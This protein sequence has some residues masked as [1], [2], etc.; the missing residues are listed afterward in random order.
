V[1]SFESYD[2]AKKAFDTLIERQLPASQLAILGADLKSAT[3]KSSWGKVILAGA[4]T[5]IIWGLLVSVLF[6]LFIP[7]RDLIEIVGLGMGFGLCYGIL[8]QVVQHGLSSSRR[9]PKEMVAQRY[10]LMAEATI[11]DQARQLLSLGPNVTSQPATTPAGSWL[12]SQTGNLPVVMTGNI[13]VVQTGSLPPAASMTGNLPIVPPGLLPDMTGNLP[14]IQTGALPPV[15]TGPLPPAPIA[16]LPAAS[17]T[18]NLPQIQ[19]GALPPSALPPVSTGPLPTTITPTSKPATKSGLSIGISKGDFFSDW[20]EGSVSPDA[21]SDVGSALPQTSLMPIEASTPAAQ[22]WRQPSIALPPVTPSYPSVNQTPP[23]PA[24]APSWDN[25][26]MEQTLIR[27]P[28][29]PPAP[30]SL[31][32]SA[33]LQQIA[34]NTGQIPYYPAQ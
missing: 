30:S 21:K 11:A 2:D 26:P 1:A 18:G 24:T 3:P 34:E 4:I 23:I 10:Q 8:A 32:S 12:P 17:M 19:T 29:Q 25:N 9:S 13:P 22:P 15:Q 7:G 20:G 5:G 6:W 16:G 31:T 33:M 14:Q 28:G 27:A